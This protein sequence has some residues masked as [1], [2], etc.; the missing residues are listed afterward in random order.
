[1]CDDVPASPSPLGLALYLV[2]QDVGAIAEWLVHTLGFAETG[3]FVDANGV[4]TN[5]ELTAGTS[6][7]LLERGD[8]PP[9]SYPRGTRWTGIWVDDP[10]E[11]Y[12]TLVAMNA[13][14][15]PPEDEPWG[16]RLVR[17]TDPEG[18]LWAL[19]RRADS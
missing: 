7:L 8:H 6:V 14:A 3:R 2:Y 19:I 11:C 18:H 17:V 4:V 16:V 15:Q 10:D 9:G 13:D 1:M 5:A 12:R